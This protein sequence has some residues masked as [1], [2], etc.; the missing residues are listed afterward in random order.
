M[1]KNKSSYCSK[2]VPNLSPVLV[3]L[4][5]LVVI[6]SEAVLSIV[7]LIDLSVFLKLGLITLNFP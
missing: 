5:P 6:K 1:L 4:Y 3:V 2:P 7:T